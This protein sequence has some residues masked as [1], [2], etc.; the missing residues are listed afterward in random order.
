MSMMSTSLFKSKKKVTFS[1]TGLLEASTLKEYLDS[2]LDIMKKDEI[3]PRIE[4]VFSFSEINAAHKIIDSGHK[5]T[6]FVLK[7]S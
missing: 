4:Q 3:S 6:N 2:L 5:K 7:T 1:A